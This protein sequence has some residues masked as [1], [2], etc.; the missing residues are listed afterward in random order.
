M[1]KGRKSDL[2]MTSLIIVYTLSKALG[3][4]PLEI[5]KM[6]TSLVKDLLNVHFVAEEL[7]AEEMEKIRRKGE[8]KF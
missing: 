6:P 1:F 5:Y 3:I 7:Q 8:S 4:S 2:K